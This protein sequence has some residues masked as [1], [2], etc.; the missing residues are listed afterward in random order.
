MK[1]PITANCGVFFA[2]LI[3]SYANG[4]TGRALYKELTK[5]HEKR[6]AMIGVLDLLTAQ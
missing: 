1:L 5:L 3:K 2:L 4:K 6:K